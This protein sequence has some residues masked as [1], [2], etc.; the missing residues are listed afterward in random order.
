MGDGI[1]GSLTSNLVVVERQVGE[2]P[3]QILS[4][5]LPLWERSLFHPAPRQPEI[6]VMTISCDLSCDVSDVS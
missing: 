6:D 3:C 2:Y 1:N 4:G 5:M